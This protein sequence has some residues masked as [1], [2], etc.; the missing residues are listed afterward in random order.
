[1]AQKFRELRPRIHPRPVGFRKN[2]MWTGHIT[3]LWSKRRQPTHHL[4]QS[5]NWNRFEQRLCKTLRQQA[6]QRPTPPILTRTPWCRT[7]VCPSPNIWSLPLQSPNF[8]WNITL[9]FH[10]HTLY[11]ST[12]LLVLQYLHDRVIG[13]LL[14]LKGDLFLGFAA[15]GVN[16]LMVP[17]YQDLRDHVFLLLIFID[18]RA[19]IHLPFSWT[20]FL[21]W[22]KST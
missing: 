22:F 18:L 9:I 13:I 21:K 6:H 7:K 1:M 12:N 4:S 20:F 16:L 10:N 19:S 14:L 17:F 5:Q 8:G 3:L 11:Y 15:V 2:V